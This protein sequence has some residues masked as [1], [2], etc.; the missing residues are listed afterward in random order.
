MTTAKGA[1]MNGKL[2]GGNM[3]TVSPGNPPAPLFL[4]RPMKIRELLEKNE[5]L[6]ALSKTK[7]PVIA[8]F[9]IA[10]ALEIIEPQMKAFVKVK[11]E[12]TVKHGTQTE[13]GRYKLDAESVKKAEIEIA[14]LLDEK[15]NLDGLPEI[16]I[17][18]LGNIEVEPEILYDL[19]GWL[20]IEGDK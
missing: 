3:L 1:G 14:P 13:D 11:N 9:R 18:D 8:S 12:M 5:S 7:L 2:V 10:K 16:S 4:R 19:M 20:L 6:V 15:A 17:Q